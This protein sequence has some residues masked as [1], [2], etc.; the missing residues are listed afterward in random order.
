LNYIG[1]HD[2]HHATL[3]LLTSVMISLLFSSFMWVVVGGLRPNHYAECNIQTDK[4][5]P[6]KML[7]NVREICASDAFNHFIQTP[8]FPS[9]HAANAF[10]CWI[11]TFLYLNGKFKIWD[12]HSHQWKVFLFFVL[13]ILMPIGIAS[14][15]YLDYHHNGSQVL[16]GSILG[17]VSGF[18]GYRL[19]YCSW[20]DNHTNHLATCFTWVSKSEFEARSSQ[21][22]EEKPWRETQSSLSSENNETVDNDQTG[23]QPTSRSTYQITNP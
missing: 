14:S 3:G 12:D 11:F 17:I 10:A 1:F 13:P 22:E 16:F 20:F 9:G 19:Y 8:A 18:I 4:I 5:I 7:Y 6:G 23:I 21:L 15:R 2:L